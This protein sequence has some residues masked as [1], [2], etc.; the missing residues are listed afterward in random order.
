MLRKAFF[1]LSFLLLF[2]SVCHSKLPDLSPKDARSKIQEILKAHVTYKNLNALLAERILQNF[3]EELDPSKTYFIE[4]EIQEWT[5]PSEAQAQKVLE[6]FQNADFSLFEKILDSMVSAIERRNLLEDEMDRSAL[7]ANV[8]PNEFKEVQ[9]THNKQELLERL[10]KIKSLQLSAAEKINQ[11]SKEQFLQLLKKRRLHRES[12]ILSNSPEQK[13]NLVMTNIL[14]STCSALD[15]HTDYFTPSEANQFLI[16]VQQRLVGIGAQLRDNLNGFAIVHLLE[17]SPAALSNK[18]KINDL[19]IAVNNE[20]IVGMDITDAVDLIR[21][22]KGTKILLTIL[23]EN[24]EDTTKSQKLDIELVRN[25]IVLEETRLE[26]SLQPYGDGVIGCLKLFSFYQDPKSSCSQ[27]LKK[28]IEKLKKEQNLKGILLDLRNNSGGLLPQ[29][30]AVTGLFI[31]KGIVCSIKEGSG[32][33]Q[34]LRNIESN[35]A[36]EGPLIVVINKASASAA[37]IVAQTLQ[38]YGRALVVGD[39]HSF[40]KGTFQTCTLDTS[41][42]GKINPQGEYK[43]TRGAY[44]T[45]SGKSPQLVGVLSDIQIPGI[46]SELDI[47]ETFSKFPL[48][49]SSIS[50][51]FDDDLSDIPPQHRRQVSLLYKNNLQTKIS[52]YFQ[53][54]EILKKNSEKRIEL[55]LN[56]QNFLKEIQKKR[57]ESE[58]VEMFGQSDL[59]LQESYNVMKDLIFLLQIHEKQVANF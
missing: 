41:R 40:G 48:E 39:K 23:R 16:Q 31:N 36:W 4:S 11:M 21:G 24:K 58:S 33:V 59:Q 47:G 6:G 57:Y 55:N 5:H 1:L 44:Y 3:L 19:I 37:E 8:D 35:I 53:Y 12:E 25:E 49:N 28:A 7:P 32:L 34:H 9:W 14:K 45:V 2:T 22:E 50:S 54:L 26:T 17:G 27:D 42:N 20:P 43:V 46:L 15:A 10:L 51:H 30:V 52:T 29:A 13:K 18:L 56:Y 38:D